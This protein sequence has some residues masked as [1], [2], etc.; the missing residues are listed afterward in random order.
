MDRLYFEEIIR[1]G[2]SDYRQLVDS[3][4]WTPVPGSTTPASKLNLTDVYKADPPTET[5][6][7]QTMMCQAISTDVAA[8]V[9]SSA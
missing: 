9:S 7:F 3:E 1:S 5:V 4:N 6:A 2:L 8:A